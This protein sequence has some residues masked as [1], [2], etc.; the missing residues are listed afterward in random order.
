METSGPVVSMGCRFVAYARPSLAEITI[1]IF[2][3]VV[4]YADAE[5]CQQSQRCAVRNAAMISSAALMTKPI[6]IT[7]DHE[8]KYESN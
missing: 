6:R 1:R 7:N 5:A 8:R 4:I 3:V 2:A